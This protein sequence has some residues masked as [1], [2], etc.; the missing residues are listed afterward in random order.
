MILKRETV[1]DGLLTDWMVK[2]AAVSPAS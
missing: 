2:S 1:D